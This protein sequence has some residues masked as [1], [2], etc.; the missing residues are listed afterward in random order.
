MAEPAVVQEVAA[1]A[2]AAPV[3]TSGGME[4][5]ADKVEVVR[6]VAGALVVDPAAVCVLVHLRVAQVAT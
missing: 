5:E 1:Q 6:G 2:A 4:M 3:V